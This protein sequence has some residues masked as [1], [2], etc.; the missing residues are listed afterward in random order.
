MLNLQWA[1]LGRNIAQVPLHVCACL[2]LW[3]E[4]SVT[5]PGKERGGNPVRTPPGSTVTSSLTSCASLMRRPKK[6]WL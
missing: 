5:R 2:L 6:S 1:S 3:E 4:R